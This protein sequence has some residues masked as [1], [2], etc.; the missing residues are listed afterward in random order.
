M[1]IF[2]DFDRKKTIVDTLKNHLTWKK[3]CLCYKICS[4]LSS[5]PELLHVNETI[6]F[7]SI[8]P[9]R[10]QQPIT[11][12]KW[13]LLSPSFLRIDVNDRNFFV[14]IQLLV[15]TEIVVNETE[16]KYVAVLQ[17]FLH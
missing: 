13:D 14:E 3:S 4:S 16:C 15:V 10:S 9:V 2:K 17:L 6:P 7:L 12:V 1:I 5:F 11:C 8:H